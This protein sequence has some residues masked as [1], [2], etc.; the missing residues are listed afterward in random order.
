LQVL[1][2]PQDSGG[3][4]LPSRSVEPGE[5][6]QTAVMQG[7]ADATHALDLHAADV[8]PVYAGAVDD[9]QNT[10]NAWL[11]VVASHLPLDYGELGDTIV[12]PSTTDANSPRWVGVDENL[13]YLNLP[14]SQTQ[15]L[16]LAVENE[17]ARLSEP[18]FLGSKTK[19][20]EDYMSVE[21]FEEGYVFWGETTDGSPVSLP[22][23]YHGER[24]V[25]GLDGSQPYETFEPQPT[26]RYADLPEDARAA[27]ETALRLEDPHV[28]GSEKIP[29]YRR[30]NLAPGQP[31]ESSQIHTA[32]FRPGYER[33]ILPLPRDRVYFSDE[34]TG[35]TLDLAVKSAE[36]VGTGWLVVPNRDNF[37]GV[38]RYQDAE[39]NF[40]GPEGANAFWVCGNSRHI[41]ADGDPRLMKADP[42]DPDGQIPLYSLVPVQYYK[43]ST[44]PTSNSGA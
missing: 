17:K 16:L 7:V 10:D 22:Y 40:F 31:G 27:V 14:L 21:L 13:A 3:W 24:V 30:L 36:K 6:L 42:E 11:E 38:A 8:E 20:Y 37:L 18:Q 23:T 35:K 33:V 32:P 41:S 4:A 1:V 25:G 44:E 43:I 5:E 28:L 12:D 29:R 19:R 9:P 2:V 15:L 26:V 34:S 39:I